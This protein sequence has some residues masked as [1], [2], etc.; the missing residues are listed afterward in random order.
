MVSACL[1]EPLPDTI[2]QG[3]EGVLSAGAPSCCS[4]H[5]CHPLLDSF[6]GSGWVWWGLVF[7]ERLMFSRLSIKQHSG[8]PP[9]EQPLAEQGAEG[10]DGRDLE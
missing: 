10:L 9:E 5:Q 2:S 6:P 8:K 3:K 7:R 1:A 4:P